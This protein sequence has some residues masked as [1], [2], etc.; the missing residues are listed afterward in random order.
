MSE[1]AGYVLTGK[2]SRVGLAKAQGVTGVRDVFSGRISGRH[3]SVTG[4]LPGHV[5]RGA[6][7]LHGGY[8]LPPSTLPAAGRAERA[9][10]GASRGELR[11][12]GSSELR[13]LHLAP[14]VTMRFGEAHGIAGARRPCIADEVRT[15]FGR[16]GEH[17]WGFQ[18]FGV[19]PDIVTMAKGIGNGVPLQSHHA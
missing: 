13:N 18:N 1:S 6:P 2:L 14:S 4:D 10:T 11:E 7:D 16:T 12:V 3:T 15:G 9:S 5:A 8:A 17:Y 19:V